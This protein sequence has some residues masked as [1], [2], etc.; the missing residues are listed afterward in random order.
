MLSS[1]PV[2]QIINVDLEL[3]N[4]DSRIYL[5]VVKNN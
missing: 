3:P 5:L 2:N 1:K 4:N